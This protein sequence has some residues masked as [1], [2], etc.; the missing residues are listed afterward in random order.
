MCM[1]V[2]ACVSRGQ[3]EHEL[4]DA[5][6]KNPLKTYQ[7]V[8]ITRNVFTLV[9]NPGNVWLDFHSTSEKYSEKG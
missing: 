6:R 7:G 5:H 3:E 9:K 2:C 8:F 4:K 1:C